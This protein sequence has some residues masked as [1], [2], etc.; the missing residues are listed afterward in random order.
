MQ[1]DRNAYRGNA[2]SQRIAERAYEDI[3]SIADRPCR[4]KSVVN[5]QMQT[6]RE[7]KIK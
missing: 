4:Q 5:K 2:D 1:T 3:H 7:M 6:D